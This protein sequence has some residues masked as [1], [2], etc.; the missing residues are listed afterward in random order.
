MPNL[1]CHTNIFVNDYDQ[2]K[3]ADVII[4][5]LGN[6]GILDTPEAKG[7]RFAELPFNQK[8]CYRSF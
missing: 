8:K 3:D 4:S 2:L 6:I 1:D 5:A 7:N